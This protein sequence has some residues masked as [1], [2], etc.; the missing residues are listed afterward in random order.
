MQLFNHKFLAVCNNKHVES[1]QRFMCP[2]KIIINRYP[3]AHVFEF[4]L[5]DVRCHVY[6]HFDITAVASAA[7][8][9]AIE[10]PAA[11]TWLLEACWRSRYF[12]SIWCELNNLAALF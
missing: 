8:I 5:V 6:F 11:I 3:F 12:T 10:A 2:D 1:P 9:H 4:H 7:R